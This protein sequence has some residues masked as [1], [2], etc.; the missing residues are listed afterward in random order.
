MKKI[1]GTIA[2][3]IALLGCNSE[4]SWRHFPY[5]AT[6]QCVIGDD[7]ATFD[8]YGDRFLIYRIGYKSAITKIGRIDS[9]PPEYNK[10][11]CANRR[12]MSR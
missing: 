1:L 7:W 12:N 6:N 4:I 2:I 9:L 11:S 3:S 8:M 10:I 5:D